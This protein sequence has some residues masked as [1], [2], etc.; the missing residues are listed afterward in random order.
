VL[1]FSAMMSLDGYTA[2]QDGAF[3]WNAPDEEVFALVNELERTTGTYLYGRRMYETMRY[4][5]DADLTGASDAT[6]E[7]AAIWR[8]ADKVVYSTSLA[9]VSTARTRI[10]RS[11]DAGAVRALARD[12]DV[13]I[14][15]PTLAAPAI[16]AGL[17]DDF[18]FFITPIIVGGGLRALPPGA[19]VALDLVDERRFAGGVAFL[20]YRPRPLGGS[21]HD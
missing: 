13:S 5:E 21:D 6:R 17:V 14:G 3:D 4:W 9:E 11:F 15:G 1:I 2:D 16:R 12:R 20:R 7:F 8:A 19:R 18:Q 10:E